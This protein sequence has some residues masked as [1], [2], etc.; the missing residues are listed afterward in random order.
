MS[1]DDEIERELALLR[2]E[3]ALELPARLHQ[4]ALALADADADRGQATLARR[5]AHQLRGSAGSYGLRAVS[6][7]A[8]D[9]EEALV[10]GQSPL[11]ALA[12]LRALI[13]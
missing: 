3:F 12:R 9:I 7:A 10:A 5:L 2:A 6:D 1:R 11:E 4:L 13:K 8:A